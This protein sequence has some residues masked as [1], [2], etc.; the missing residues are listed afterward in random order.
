MLVIILKVIETALRKVG[1]L[2]T[3]RRPSSHMFHPDRPL[4]ALIG[5]QGWYGH[6][7]HDPSHEGENDWINL[8]NL[9]PSEPKSIAGHINKT[10]SQHIINWSSTFCL[11]QGGDQ[12]MMCWPVVL[13]M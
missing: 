6:A 11:I 4:N 10:T 9:H 13:L 7:V 12:F 8:P 5:R 1:V 2:A 3:L